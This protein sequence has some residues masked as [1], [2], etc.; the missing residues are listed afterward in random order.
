MLRQPLV[1][2]RVVG[3]QQFHHAAILAHDVLEEQLG[4]ALEALAQA[5]VEL[6][7]DVRI[8]LLLR[9][10]AQVEP[11]PGE[12]RDQRFGAR[13]VQHAPHLLVQHGGV[14]QL[15]LLRQV[16]QLVVGNAAPQE[17]GE[18]RRQ[19]QIAD[20]IDAAGRAARRILLDAEEEVGR[21]QQRAQRLLDAEI[22]IALRAAAAI[23][24]QQRLEVGIG[25]RTAEGAAAHAGQNGAGAR[26]LV[27]RGGRA[28]HKDPG[29]AGRVAGTR[30]VIRSGDRDAGRLRRIVAFGD[31]EA[32]QLH[33][34]QAQIQFGHR[35]R[36]PPPPPGALPRRQRRRARPPRSATSAFADSRR[37]VTPMVRRPAAT[38]WR[39]SNLRSGRRR[40]GRAFTRMTYSASTGK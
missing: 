29:A 12:I 7:E 11:L 5:L 9:E 36:D 38:G 14:L 34:I 26:F 10:I 37:N 13:I 18:P 1:E 6:G 8:G 19:F 33:A 35:R 25:H 22:E 39:I 28:A 24:S 27:L 16:Q 23:K 4:L 2:E 31:F 40:P 21:N 3:I 17:E 30:D 20:A 32:L 15:A